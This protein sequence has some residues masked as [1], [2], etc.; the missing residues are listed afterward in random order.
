VFHPLFPNTEEY[1][2]Q[3]GQKAIGKAVL[4]VTH[5]DTISM[6]LQICYGKSS[7]TT[8]ICSEYIEEDFHSILMYWAS[9]I[10]TARMC[11][12]SGLS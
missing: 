7:I 1:N 3:T 11:K 12:P 2:I 5:R 4:G 9:V 10:F 8:M 6:I